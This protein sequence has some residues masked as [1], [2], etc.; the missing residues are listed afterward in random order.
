MSLR[1][2]VLRVP[3]RIHL[4]F[5][6]VIA[7]FGFVFFLQG[8]DP[9]GLAMFAAW[10]P[11]STFA[12][13]SHELGHAFIGRA[14]GLSPRVLVHGL[15]GAT[16]FSTDALRKL[17]HGKRALVA[18]AGP[19]VGVGLGLLAFVAERSLALP[20]ESV[21][22]RTLTLFFWLSCGWGVVN[23]L[24]VLPLDGGQVVAALLDRATGGR[25]LAWARRSSVALGLLCAGFGVHAAELYLLA[26]GLFIAAMN[27][28]ASLATRPGRTLPD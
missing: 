19:A 25:G 1:L 14:F 2:L 17:T 9:D 16:A 13:L 26:L 11:C 22:K 5:F 10:I 27:A 21:P 12:M 24:P 4:S 18:L 20:P 8:A 3:V 6:T 23:L 28:W 7:L 15:G